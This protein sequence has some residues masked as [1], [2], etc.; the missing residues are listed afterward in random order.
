MNSFAK[1]RIERA[2]RTL[3]GRI[4]CR[5]LGEQTGAVLMEY[6]VL[7]VLVVAAVVGAVI[8]FGGTISNA[9][10]TMGKAIWGQK[11][12]VVKQRD[13]GRDATNTGITDAETHRTSI[14][15]EPGSD[16]GEGGATSA[17]PQ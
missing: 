17:D 1:A 2:K 13:A 12:E 4:V 14:Q 15:G 3:F 8:M 5:L 6:V 9:F 7:G 16:G 10:A 11:D